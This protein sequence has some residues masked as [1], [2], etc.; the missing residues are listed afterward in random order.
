MKNVG[1]VDKIDIIYDY[2]DDFEAY[3]R[4]GI[5]VVRPIGDNIK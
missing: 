5:H 3:S 1:R 2:T 4:N